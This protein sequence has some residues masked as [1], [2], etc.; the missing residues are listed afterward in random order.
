MNDE[1]VQVQNV[2]VHI[3]G[4]AVLENNDFTVRANDFVGIIGPNGAGKTT[5]LKVIAGLIKPTEGKVTVFGHEPRQVRH[6]IGYVPQISF[7]DRD[8]PISVWDTVLMGRLSKRSLFKQFNIQD[9]Q[10]ASEALR[11]IEMYDLKD[12][13]VG[14]LSGGERQRIFIARA[15]ASQPKL[16]LLDEPTASVDQAMKTSIYD[17]LDTLKKDMSIV[18]VTHDVGVIS[19]H[20]DKIACLNC[21]LHYHDNKEITRETLEAL[22][23][24]PVDVIA[25]GI[26]HRVLKKH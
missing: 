3:D 19:S 11:A 6:M 13:Q 5:L 21:K 10:I 16:L 20:V 7:F 9:R 12:R 26:P 17:L 25:H 4:I 14:E 2:S 18:L 1:I 8:F 15:L 24:C 23:H 22:Y